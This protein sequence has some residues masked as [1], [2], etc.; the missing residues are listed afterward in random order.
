MRGL[1]AGVISIP[2]VLCRIRTD[3]EALGMADSQL[4]HLRLDTDTIC[5]SQ[6]MNNDILHSQDMK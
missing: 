4:R 3:I 1:N 5:I 2:R 6:R